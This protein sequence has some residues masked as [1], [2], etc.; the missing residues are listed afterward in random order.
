MLLDIQTTL[1]LKNESLSESNMQQECS[2]CSWARKIALYESDQ[3]QLRPGFPEEKSTGSE[4]N[5][6]LFG[7]LLL[8]FVSTLLHHKESSRQQH[9]PDIFHLVPL[10][11]TDLCESRNTQQHLQHIFI[12]M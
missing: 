9:A 11:C 4:K 7:A 2:I 8:A 5:N 6:W 10:W 12:Y 1:Y 3:Q